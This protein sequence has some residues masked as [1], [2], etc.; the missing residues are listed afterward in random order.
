VRELDVPPTFT[1]LEI[2]GQVFRVVDYRESDPTPE[3]IGRHVLLRLSES[4][5]IDLWKLIRPGKLEI[6]RV[7]VD[8]A[9]IPMRLGRSIHWSE[10][11]VDGERYFK[12]ALHL[13]PPDLPPPSLSMASGA[14]QD[15]L[16]SIVVALVARVKALS[17]DLA[18]AG[19]LTDER[20]KELET[21]AWTQ[22]V[23]EARADVIG[24]K[25]YQVGDAAE[26]L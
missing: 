7:G 13:F 2:D 22:L 14:E 18:R 5:L 10:H 16:A 24:R 21:G 17:N 4:E 12:Q 1:E 11:V 15:A 19:V 20:R 25:L 9:P 8:E 3:G 26:H 6:R 23:D